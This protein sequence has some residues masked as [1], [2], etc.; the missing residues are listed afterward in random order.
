MKQKALKWVSLSLALSLSLPL[1]ASCSHGKTEGN[2]NETDALVFSSGE[3]DKVFNPFFYTSAY[4][5]TIAGQTQIGMLGSDD[6]GNN[7][8]Y[9]KDEPVV[10]LDYSEIMYDA[11]GEI[12]KDGDQNGT[13]VYQMVLKNDIKFSDGVS[14]T[15]H[16]V[17]FNM[18]MYL[19]PVYTGSSTMYSV[20]IQGL[21]NYQ[22]QEEGNITEGALA[23]LDR[24]FDALALTRIEAIAAYVTPTSTVSWETKVSDYN[25]DRRNQGI[26]VAYDEAGIKK[27]IE[28]TKEKWQEELNSDW[29][30]AS[31]QLETYKKEYPFT[32]VWQVFFYMEG[33]IS[34]ESQTIAG[35]T[36]YPKDED[37]KY[38][39]DWQGNEGGSFNKETAIREVYNSVL[40]E[41]GSNVQQIATILSGWATAETMAT[42]FAAED[43]SLYYAARTDEDGNAKIKSISGIKILSGS[44]FKGTKKYDE[45]YSKYEMLQITIDGVDPKA[46]WNFGFTVAPMHYYSTPELT[47]AAMEDTTYSSN[48][49]VQFS[50][51]EFMTSVKRRN[52]VPMGA[53]AYQASTMQDYVYQWS[54]NASEENKSFETLKDGFYKDGIVYFVRNEYFYTTGGNQNEVYNAKIKHMQYKVVNSSQTMTALQG[55]SIHFADPSATT[56]NI[57]IVN[58]DAKLDRIMVDTAGYGYIGINASYVNSVYVRRAIMSVM[59]I[60]L[61]QN[62]YPDDLSSPI[63]RPFSK[64]SWVYDY[65]VFGNYEK[66]IWQPGS[67]TIDDL[68]LV[69][70]PNT[71]YYGFDDSFEIGK[72][73]LE[74]EPDCK[75]SGGKWYYD[76]KPLKFTFTIAGDTTDHPAYKTMLLARDI[77]NKNGFEIEVLP[78]ATALSKLANGEL[79]IWAAA[80]SASNDPDMYQVYHKDSKATSIKNWGYDWIAKS[81]TSY[82]KGILDDLAELIEEGRKYI[83]PGMR[84]PIYQEASDLV[85]DLAVELPVYQRSDMYV[86]NKDVLDVT[87]FKEKPTAYASPLNELWKVSFKL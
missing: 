3:F 5:G 49:G 2:K 61:V 85:M 16:D 79:A 11:R 19:D 81:G 64:V 30:S 78:D 20:A 53:G 36:T 31:D 84:A 44:E 18:Y 71:S 23:A 6:A 46:K 68:G 40:G 39:I 28:T 24:T 51:N 12:S 57:D 59:D 29:N 37:G 13:T 32:E 38:K 65:D 25:R 55:G 7:V 76:G 83:E 82:E 33:L 15:A 21:K 69:S 62:Y 50:S 52:L 54:E 67:L 14:L 86:Y 27:D 10:A 66:G 75:Y 80:W 72:Y 9:G 56:E 74:Q 45:D 17:L 1:I 42:E 8:T 87:T 41:D 47:K 34:R 48:F 4:D 22:L 35:V 26:D 63:Y 77:L 43:K 70:T 73:W 60:N 58:R